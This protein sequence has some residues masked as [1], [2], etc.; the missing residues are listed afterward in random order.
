MQDLLGDVL[1]R[2]FIRLDKALAEVKQELE[3]L[4]A[5]MDELE[6]QEGG[7]ECGQSNIERKQATP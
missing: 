3:E 6:Q 2:A 4:K 1:I 7:K 5:Q